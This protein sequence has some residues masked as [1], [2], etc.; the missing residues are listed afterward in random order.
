MI[1]QTNFPVHQ[2]VFMSPIIFLLFALML[3]LSVRDRLVTAVAPNSF[4]SSVNPVSQPS[5]VPS[6][7]HE[8]NSS[9]PTPPQTPAIN[10]KADQIIP[11]VAIIAVEHSPAIEPIPTPTLTPPTPTAISLP[12]AIPTIDPPDQNPCPPWPITVNDGQIHADR[13]PNIICLDSGSHSR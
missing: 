11:R 3:P 10:V 4:T 2:G 12:I 6:P 9:V 1:H 5:P 7:P 13:D 8:N